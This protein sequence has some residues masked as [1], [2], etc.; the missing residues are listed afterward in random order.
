MFLIV[1][2]SLCT[3]LKSTQMINPNGSLLRV[4]LKTRKELFKCRENKSTKKILMQQNRN[5]VIRFTNHSNIYLQTSVNKFINLLMEYL[6]N[7]FMN[8]KS[9]QFSLTHHSEY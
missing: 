6:L 9:L 8:E 5:L 4:N 7:K 1:T 3:N 2:L